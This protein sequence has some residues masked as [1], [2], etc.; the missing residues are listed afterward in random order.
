MRKKKRK[1][2]EEKKEK[3]FQGRKEKL[4]LRLKSLKVFRNIHEAASDGPGMLMQ[5]LGG[6]LISG[7]MTVM[8]KWG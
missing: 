6:G 3:T 1:K 4:A 5:S 7:M 2:K 8:M